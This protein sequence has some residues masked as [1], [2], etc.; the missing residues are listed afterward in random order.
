MTYTIVVGVDGSPHS[1]EALRWSLGQAERQH[2]QV[3]AVFAWQMPFIG[4]PGAYDRG[5][6]EAIAS[7]FLATRLNEVAPDPKVPLVALAAEGDP[8]EALVEAARDADL[9]VVGV[10]GR[11]P[12]TGLMMGAVSQRCAALT[13]CPV[14]L[15]K[16]P[17][18]PDDGGVANGK[19]M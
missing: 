16:S 18:K 17:A 12:L 9:L 8:T 15:V 2:G 5:E 3:K 10:R 1:D 4:I 13:H 11:S 6:L 14:V 19:T 7:Q